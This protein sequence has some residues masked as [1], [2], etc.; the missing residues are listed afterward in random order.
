ME[1]AMNSLLAEMVEVIVHESNPEKVILF[2]SHAKDNADKDSDI[3]LLIIESEPFGV[4][5]SRLKEISKIQRALSKF[6]VPKDIL[7]YS[8]EEVA[9]WGDSVNHV[10]SR[11]LREG[12]TLYERC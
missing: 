10:I 6:M 11:S 4:K 3:D 8:N 7:V 9:K 12:K 5:R 1:I 2:G